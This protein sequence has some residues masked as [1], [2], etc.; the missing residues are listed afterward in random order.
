MIRAI[1]T[2]DRAKT[3]NWIKDTFRFNIINNQASK[4]TMN[5]EDEYFIISNPDGLMGIAI[6]EFI[7]SPY[8]DYRDYDFINLARTR[9]RLR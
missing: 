5:N 3:I 4:V 6:H 8:F 1:L 7:V 9:M 2:N